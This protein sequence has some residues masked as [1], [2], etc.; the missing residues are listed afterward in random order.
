ML[1]LELI[2]EGEKQWNGKYFLYFFSCAENLQWN[3]RCILSHLGRQR[4]QNLEQSLSWTSFSFTSHS[5]SVM[6]TGTEYVQAIRKSRRKSVNNFGYEQKCSHYWGLYIHVQGQN[7]AVHPWTP[8][9]APH[10]LPQERE[11]MSFSWSQ[12]PTPLWPHFLVN[13][14]MK[15]FIYTL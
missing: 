5:A 15:D 3:F 8:K 13:R 6:L 1:P 7:S 10:L 4:V 2:E 12:V 11:I 9:S 14:E